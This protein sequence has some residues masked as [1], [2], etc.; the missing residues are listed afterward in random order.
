MIYII[1]IRIIHKDFEIAKKKFINIRNFDKDFDD[2]Q[3]KDQNYRI[4]THKLGIIHKDFETTKFLDHHHKDRVR[5]GKCGIPIFIIIRIRI[6][7]FTCS[8]F[9][10]NRYKIKLYSML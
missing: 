1:I 4:Q 2:F 5:K 3:G 10:F 9:I 6:Q 7:D 8:S